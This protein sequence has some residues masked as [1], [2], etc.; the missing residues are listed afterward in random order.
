[1]NLMDTSYQDP[2]QKLGVKRMINACNWST[3][4]G[5][6]YLEP[7]VI[8]AMI[9]ASKTFVNMHDLINKACNRIAELCK[10]DAAYITSGAAAGITMSVAACIAGKE[11]SKWAR[12]P[13]TDD[14]PINGRNQIIIQTNQSAYEEQFAAG[15]GRLIKVGGPG[16]TSI[17][18]IESAINENTVA[19]AAGYHYNTTPRGCVPYPMLPVIAKKN[20][21]CHALSILLALSHPMRTYT[22]S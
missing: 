1:M 8:E 14:S 17:D 21:A 12:L 2:F 18:A 15:G 13:F 3:N 11:A 9:Q 16:G 10:V 6:T 5:G 4:I 22:N 20:M 19:I 7:E